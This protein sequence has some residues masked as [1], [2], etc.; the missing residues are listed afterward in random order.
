MEECSLGKNPGQGR[1][2]KKREGRKGEGK[3]KR[4]GKRGKSEGGR[5]GKG[6]KESNEREEMM[7]RKLLRLL[8]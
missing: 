1:G 6:R 4:K 5:E 8:N 2:E 3:A 7:E